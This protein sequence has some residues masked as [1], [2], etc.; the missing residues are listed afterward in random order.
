M[1][2][3]SCVLTA[4]LLFTTGGPL[5]A[6]TWSGDK[7]SSYRQAG[8]KK[9]L[10]ARIVA[11]PGVVEV[12][13]VS[14][15]KLVARFDKGNLLV[16][17]G[18]KVVGSN[19]ETKTSWGIGLGGLAMVVVGLLLMATNTRRVKPDGPFP[20]PFYA[21]FGLSVVGA[22]ISGSRFRRNPYIEISDGLKKI[23]LRVKKKNMNAFHNDIES[24]LGQ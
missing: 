5:R 23:E 22:G 10:K 20:P 17:K 19:L 9:W 11:S 2:L 16:K 14:Q 21:G 15:G 8:T 13:S 1:K 18:G 7:K 4:S 12:F 3:V 24:A 6:E